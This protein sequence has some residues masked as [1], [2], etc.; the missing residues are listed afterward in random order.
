[1]AISGSK[2]YTKIKHITEK[3]RG[4]E[5]QKTVTKSTKK[6]RKKGEKSE[7]K[8][9]SIKKGKKRGRFRKNQI[10][11]K[12]MRGLRGV[13]GLAVAIVLNKY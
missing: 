3:Q 11:K 7:K 4:C 6:N 5:R 12:K 13:L 8:R 9:S 10:Q 2:L 1:L